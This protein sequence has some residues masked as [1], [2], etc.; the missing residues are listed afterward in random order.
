[1]RLR[2]A[3]SRYYVP[4]MGLMTVPTIANGYDLPAIGVAAGRKASKGGVPVCVSGKPYSS[5]MYI[6]C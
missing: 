2:Y 1:M 3:A 4:L 6:S 5:P